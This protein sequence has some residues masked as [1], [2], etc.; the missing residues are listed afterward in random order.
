MTGAGDLRHRLA[1]EEPQP[2]SDGAGGFTESWD[3][4]ATVWAALVPSGGVEAVESGRLAGRVTHDVTLRYRV[5]VTPAMRFRQGTRLFHILSVID[6]DERK[7][8]LRC[9]CEERDL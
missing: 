5:G 1:L 8:W 3:T 9:Q 4:V 2:V 6:D 7:T